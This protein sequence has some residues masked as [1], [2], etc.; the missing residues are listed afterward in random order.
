MV[1]KLLEFQIDMDYFYLR[2]FIWNKPMT[3]MC[4]I[5]LLVEKQIK[6]LLEMFGIENKENKAEPID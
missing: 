3:C 2:S 6:Y 4:Y 1:L 5:Y